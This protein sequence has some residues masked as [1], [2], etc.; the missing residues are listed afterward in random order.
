MSNAPVPGVGPALERSAVPLRGAE[1]ATQ[2]GVLLRGFRDQSKRQRAGEAAQ[3]GGLRVRHQLALL[4]ALMQLPD[5]ALQPDLHPHAPLGHACRDVEDAL[6][7]KVGESL[8][9]LESLAEL[10]LVARRLINHVNLCPRC[11]A[12][13]INFRETCPSCSTIELGIE[14]LVHHFACAHVGPESEFAQ[15]I[16]LV[17]PKCERVLNQLGQDFD[18][19]GETYL[20]GVG[21]HIFEEP[22]LEA[23]CLSCAAVFPGHETQVQQVFAYRATPLASRAVELNRLTGLDVSEMLLDAGLGIATRTF[24]LVELERELLRLGEQPGCFG[25]ATVEFRAEGQTFP[26]FSRL[27]AESL[28][29]LARTIQGSLRSLDLACRWNNERLSLLLLGADESKCHVI[30]ERVLQQVQELVLLGDNRQPLDVHWRS[31]SYTAA[32]ISSAKAMGFL[33]RGDPLP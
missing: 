8:V 28:R 5:P 32:G 23:Q 1:A 2:L 7:L 29:A 25:L 6:D 19:P 16:D 18:R 3:T 31:Q 4:R 33:D 20:C 24:F 12:C 13:Q 26:L 27:S 30:R 10:G 17:C 21:G 9:L 11:A 22:A 15:G 14:R